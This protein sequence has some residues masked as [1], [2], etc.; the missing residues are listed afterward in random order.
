VLQRVVFHC[1]KKLPSYSFQC[2]LGAEDVQGT[3]EIQISDIHFLNKK[4]HKNKLGGS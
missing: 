2:I 1:H 4:L 3:S